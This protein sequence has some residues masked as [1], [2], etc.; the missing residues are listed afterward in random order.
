M[1]RIITLLLFKTCF[2]F[3][4]NCIF[5]HAH[6]NAVRSEEGLL[7]QIGQ[8]EVDNESSP[9]LLISELEGLIQTSEQNDYRDAY[10]S[11]MLLKAEL[12]FNSD[13]KVKAQQTIETLLDVTD[14][15][16][17]ETSLKTSARIKL[18]RLA[19]S[20]AMGDF[21]QNQDKRDELTV[22]A[23]QV[24]DSDLRGDMYLGL[25][26][27]Q[28]D[29]AQ[30]ADAIESL[31]LAYNDFE[32]VGNNQGLG[33]VM[34]ALGNINVTLGNIEA[35]LSDFQQ[36]LGYARLSKDK[37][38]E[39]IL[40]YNISQAHFQLGELE[41]ASD[42]IKEALSLSIELKDGVGVTWANNFRGRILLEQEKW[43]QA[44]DIF[45][46]TTQE[47]EESGHTRVHFQSL[48]ALSYALGR[49]GQIE[50]AANALQDAKEHAATFNDENTD[51]QV[52]RGVSR[53]SYAQGKY[54][55][56]YDS[57]EQVLDLQDK[58]HKQEQAAQIQK[59]RIEFDSDLKDRQNQAL[60]RE[61]EL[62]VTLLQKQ[63]QLEN[64]WLALGVA[65][66]FIL[67]MLGFSLYL[68]VKKR[69]QYKELAHI[70]LLTKAPNRRSIMHRA[71]LQFTQ[72]QTG[73]F[74]IAL[75]DIDNFKQVNDTYGHDV[76][77]EVLLAFAE[78]CELAIRKKD[79]YGRYGGE[80]WLLVFDGAQASNTQEIFKRLR[81][82]LQELKPLSLPDSFVIT[83]SMGVATFDANIDTNLNQLI[84]RADTMLYKAKHQG[85]D[86]I[87]FDSG[88]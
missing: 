72:A 45:T 39:S 66:I 41:A 51:L 80:E 49:T 32:L 56:A 60:Q 14:N 52:A 79:N 38:D 23:E 31:K 74:S 68:Q 13:N 62:T 36:A 19:I 21:M 65:S 17:F 9:H 88:T 77:D 10:S 86:Q 85:K 82:A 53:L 61:N 22:L 44:A 28:F 33:S 4:V 70:D 87:V 20:D 26:H 40:L 15:S 1:K 55:E 24:E 42:K 37:F 7:A 75:L 46:K 2:L 3:M 11:A 50:K 43:Q 12:L 25:A 84:S 76:G 54:K 73:K 18:L 58:I 6:A 67:A 78:A 57:L 27:S 47:F 5:P 48:L 69:N 35:G 30:F 59:Y 81:A 64:V 29:S 83:F 34:S 16:V 71:K 63:K 8:L